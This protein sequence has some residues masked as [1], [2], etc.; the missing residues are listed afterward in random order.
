MSPAYS[1]YTPSSF[2]NSHTRIYGLAQLTATFG[3]DKL[4]ELEGKRFPI[5]VRDD[6]VRAGELLQIALFSWVP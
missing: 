2:E 1:S 6:D 5:P 3:G 4:G